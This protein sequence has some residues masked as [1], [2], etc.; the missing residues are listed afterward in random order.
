MEQAA[1]ELPVD[2]ALGG[3]GGGDGREAHD[4]RFDAASSGDITR[5]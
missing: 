3:W 4:I 5:D 2:P 1:E